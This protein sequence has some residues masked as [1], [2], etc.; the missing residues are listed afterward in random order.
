MTNDYEFVNSLPRIKHLPHNNGETDNGAQFKGDC[1]SEQVPKIH[2]EINS[3]SFKYSP[4][5]FENLTYNAEKLNNSIEKKA[6]V[7]LNMYHQEVENLQVSPNKVVNKFDSA[8]DLIYTE[9]ASKQ[10]NVSDK[11]TMRNGFSD[12]KK[13]VEENALSQKVTIVSSIMK[14]NEKSNLRLESDKFILPLENG[15]PNSPPK[16]KLLITHS[17]QK[18]NGDAHEHTNGHSKRE[19]SDSKCNINKRLSAEEIQIHNVERHTFLRQKVRKSSI[20]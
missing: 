12:T 4:K 8:N 20:H 15:F 1:M 2:A 7:N 6:E 13:V 3:D 9:N 5:H 18:L 10:A 19:I 16:E 17:A 14:S 11:C